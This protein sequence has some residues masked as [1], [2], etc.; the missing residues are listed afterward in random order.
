M[1]DWLNPLKELNEQIIQETEI[2]REQN[3]RIKE[4]TERLQRKNKALRFPKSN[5]TPMIDHYRVA[6][7]TNK[8]DY[9]TATYLTMAEALAA[10]VSLES[11]YQV[12]SVTTI[13]INM[14]QD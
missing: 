4:H 14:G 3:E 1:T 8:L 9:L 12:I 7:T 5:L 6:Y 11:V 13:Y 2:I 10:A